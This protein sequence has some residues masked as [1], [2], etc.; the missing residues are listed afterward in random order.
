MKILLS[1]GEGLGNTIQVL[2]LLKGL[3]K[4]GLDVTILNLSYVGNKD[5]E[6]LYKRYATIYDHKSPYSDFDGHI[7]LATTKGNLRDSDRW[8]LPL[9]N[10]IDKQYIYSQDVNEVNVYL[11]VLKDFNIEITDDLFDIKIGPLNKQKNKKF[12]F[13]LHNGCS[14]V[15]PKQWERKKYIHME[16]LAQKLQLIGNVTS[17]G[18]KDEYCGGEN[19]TGLSLKDTASVIASSEFFISNDTGTYHLASAMKKQGIVIFTATSVYKNKHDKFH[20]SMTVFSKCMDCQPCQYTDNWK[21]CSDM[22]FNKLACRDIDPEEII[23]VVKRCLNM[24]EKT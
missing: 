11:E 1:V 18:A 17:V 13:C 19:N 14:R 22:S 3:T 10:N 8:E 20:D 23:K 5:L 21:Y 15:N 16:E 2:P 12:T 7:E 9:L 24:E 6:W 4:A